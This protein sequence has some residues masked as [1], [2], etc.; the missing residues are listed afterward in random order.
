MADCLLLSSL[1][2]VAWKQSCHV[3]VLDLVSKQLLPSKE[4][5]FKPSLVLETVNKFYKSLQMFNL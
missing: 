5:K 2:N 4:G 1:E 3:I